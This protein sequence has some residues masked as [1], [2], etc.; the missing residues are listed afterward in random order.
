[1]QISI[2]EGDKAVVC[3]CLLTRH[4]FDDNII[5]TLK[6]DCL[7][8]KERE[9][10]IQIQGSTKTVIQESLPEPLL[11]QREMKRFCSARKQHSA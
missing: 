8:I 9:L 4:F 6:V 5:K 1:M 7:P 2:D 11:E 10:E 3:W